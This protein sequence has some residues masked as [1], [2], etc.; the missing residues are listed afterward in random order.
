MA[1]GWINNSTRP[2]NRRAIDENPT[3]HSKA[4]R[5]Y[6][7]NPTGEDVHGSTG[8][9]PATLE[10]RPLPGSVPAKTQTDTVPSSG[11]VS[12]VGYAPD[13]SGKFVLPDYSKTI[14]K[15]NAGFQ[16]GVSR[17]PQDP[18]AMTPSDSIRKR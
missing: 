6:G 12:T 9:Q 5:R 7:R 14:G 16:G 4:T 2:A 15:H 13:G 11:L 3:V 8:E 18:R 17:A 1:I 10:R